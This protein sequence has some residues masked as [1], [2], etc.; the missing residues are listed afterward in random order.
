[1]SGYRQGVFH[2][3]Y[4]TNEINLHFVDGSSL[5]TAQIINLLP[6]NVYGTNYNDVL[7]GS[8]KDNSIY[9]YAGNDKIYDPAGKDY[10][11]AD[12]GNDTIYC[13]GGEAPYYG[14]DKGDT[15]IAGD[16]DD[17][18]YSDMMSSHFGAD[19]DFIDGGNGND[20]KKQCKDC[21]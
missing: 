11:N 18:V 8:T 5:D 10:I 6:T 16:G 15:M 4:G 9:G 3:T 17:K 19:S 2:G 21:Y 7:N 20:Y 13:E 14:F 12:S 1:M